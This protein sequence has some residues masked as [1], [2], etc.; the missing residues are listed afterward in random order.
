MRFTYNNYI[1]DISVPYE[2]ESIE[3]NASKI[4]SSASI[5]GLGKINND[6]DKKTVEII[7][8][9]ETG[10]TRTYTINITRLEKTPD[11]EVIVPDISTIMNNSGVKYN[12]NYVFGIN[13]NTSI[14]GLINNI[15]EIGTYASVTVK[16]SNGNNK[17]DDIF[18]TGD[19]ITITNTK[20][21]KEYKVL[22]YGDVNGDGKIDKDDCLA[23]LRHINN[24]TNLNE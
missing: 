3:I 10:R 22:I 18:K 4:S 15:K 7:V 11:I 6:S 12:D 9:A 1:Y 23:V 16:D 2:K 20:E 17:E 19:V 13:E 14:K 8:A 21:T 24:Y 5:K